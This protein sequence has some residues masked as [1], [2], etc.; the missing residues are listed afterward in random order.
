MSE[1]RY[2]GFIFNPADLAEGIDVDLD[3]RKEI[4]FVEANLGR[5][6][7][8]DLLGIPWDAPVEVAK[9]A[10]LEKVKLFHPDRYPGRKLGSFRARLEKIFP[11]LVEA[12]D[13]LTDATRRVAYARATAPATEVAKMEARKIEDE[14]RSEERRA[15]LA[16]QS[17]LLARAARVAELMKRGREA[18]QAARFQEAANDFALVASLDPSNREAGELAAEARKRSTASK[19][20]EFVDKAAA[21]EVMGHFGQ[22]L[23]SYR[24]ALEVDRSNMR[25]VLQ[26]S[27]AALQGGEAAVARELAEWAVQLSP[28]HGAAHEALGLALELGGRK[29]EAKKALERAV[30]LDPKLESAKERLKKLRWSFLG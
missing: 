5:F 7:H 26:A 10:Y 22:A 12:R 8:Y 13:V 18:L 4:L 28:R 24:A 25:V 9:A 2:K 14:R 30:E 23:A 16:R 11:R 20:Q 1:D 15:R 29:G 27:R 17:P 3:R 21:A 6:T 19:V